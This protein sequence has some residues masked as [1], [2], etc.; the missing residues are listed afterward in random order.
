MLDPHPK[1]LAIDFGSQRIGLA[2]SFGILAEPLTIIPNDEIAVQYVCSILEDYRV[3][4]LLIGISEGRM[5]EQSREF[6]ALLARVTKVPIEYADE[7]LSTQTVRKKLKDA[8]KNPD[9]FVDHF[10]AAEILQQWMD[11]Q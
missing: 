9:Q 5:A 2:I 3:T 4:K 7:T 11:E 6:G 1:I 8:G 10:A